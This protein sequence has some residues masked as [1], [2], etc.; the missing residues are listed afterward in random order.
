LN[1]KS[2]TKYT[3][4]T[5]QTQQ[6]CINTSILLWQHV[7]VLVET[8]SASVQRYELKSMHIMYYGIPYVI[9]T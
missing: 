5:V 6:Q 7:S 3:K 9:Y 8:S 1:C 2:K 4:F